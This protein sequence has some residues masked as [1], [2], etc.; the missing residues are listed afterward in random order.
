MRRVAHR[1]ITVQR[2]AEAL[3]AV[4]VVAGGQRD[5]QGCAQMVFDL[6]A[7]TIAL[8]AGQFHVERASVLTDLVQTPDMGARHAVSRQARVVECGPN[9]G[10]HSGTPPR[11][12]LPGWN[13]AC[14]D[15]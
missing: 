12:A 4:A 11:I 2:G 8:R 1:Q 15:R 7:Q 5:L 9:Q 6:G 3:R 13:T 14:G 10:Q